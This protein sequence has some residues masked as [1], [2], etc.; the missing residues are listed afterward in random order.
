MKYVL[1]A[2]ALLSGKPLPP[3]MDCCAPPS[4]AEEVTKGRAGNAASYLLEA[5]LEVVTPS[6]ASGIKVAE[7]AA[8]TGDSSR[9]SMQDMD[10]LALA[11]DTGA[12]LLTDDYSMQ[13][14]ATVLGLSFQ[15]VSQRGIAQVWS[16]VRRCRGC[17]K[18]WP[19]G[20]SECPDCGSEIQVKRARRSA[21]EGERK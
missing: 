13:N 11:L 4:V 21:G 15:T 5:G 18:E 12:T 17:K 6:V 19:Q 2:S 1:D 7:A 16:W 3:A 14:L 20:V 10:A 8:R 9:V